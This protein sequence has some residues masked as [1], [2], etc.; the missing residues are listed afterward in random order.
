MEDILEGS[1]EEYVVNNPNNIVVS[2]IYNDNPAIVVVDLIN[3]DS[4]VQNNEREISFVLDLC[5]KHKIKKEIR[6]VYFLNNK[7]DISKV[8]SDIREKDPEVILS[9][10]STSLRKVF[11][12]KELYTNKI[13]ESELLRQIPIIPTYGPYKVFINPKSSNVE[14]LNKGFEMA[15]NTLVQT[16]VHT[17]NLLNNDK[18]IIEVREKLEKIMKQIGVLSKFIHSL[19]INDP[20]YDITVNKIEQLEKEKEDN[21]NI[22]RLLLRSKRMNTS[23]LMELFSGDRK[24]YASSEIILNYEQ[25]KKFCSENIDNQTEI[26]YDVETNALPVMDVNHEIV[27]FSLASEAS[28]G[29]YVPFKALDFKMNEEDKNKIIEDL[30]KTLLEKEIWVYNC[31]H[32]IPVV[33]NNYGIFL[34]DIKDLYVIIKLLNC[35]KPWESGSRTL[36]HQVS[37][38]LFKEDW[39]ED[40]NTYFTLFRQLN[41][42]EI[43]IEMK[44]LLSKYYELTEVEPTLEK[45]IERYEDLKSIL[46]STKVISY[47]NVPYKLIGRYG[48]LDSS[49]LFMLRDRYYEEITE[50]NDLLGIDLMKGFDLWQKIH[51]AHIMMEMNGLYLNDKKVQKLDNW[52][53]EQSKELM[54]QIVTSPLTRSWIK[55]NYWYE[56]SRN[57]LMMDYID[58]I[59]DRDTMAKVVQGRNGI[60]KDHIK[61]YKITPLF[62]H[63]IRKINDLINDFNAILDTGRDFQDEQTFD[64]LL[65]S[66]EDKDLRNEYRELFVVMNEISRSKPFV[67][68]KIEYSKGEFIVKLNWQNLLVIYRL[69]NFYKSNKNLFDE[70]FDTWLNEQIENSNTFDD[71]KN[72]FNVNSTVKVF[73]DYVS[74]ILLSRSIKI[75]HTYY[76][77]YEFIESASFEDDLEALKPK[78]PR[79]GQV[80]YDFM[81]DYLDFM[82]NTK[83]EE[84]FSPKRLEI[85]TDLF[86]K[87]VDIKFLNDLKYKRKLKACFDWWYDPVDTSRISNYYKLSTL[88]SGMIEHLTQ[89]YMMLNCNIDDRTTWTDEF[90]FMFNYKFIKKLIKAKST[91][92]D[93]STGR[94]NAYYID[95][96]YYLKETFPKRLSTY[97]PGNTINSVYDQDKAIEFELEDG[98]KIA[99]GLNDKVELQDGTIKLAKDITVEDDIIVPEHISMHFDNEDIDDEEEE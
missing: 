15:F 78:N 34:K 29:C 28:T 68:I 8:I 75:A 93:G 14:T 33:Y 65:G 40:L 47:E 31:Q 81:I 97:E 24:I 30:K 60:T 91:Y 25:Y 23:Q 48:S 94:G 2:G 46:S 36:K 76:K 41:K 21:S 56:F 53:D 37:T 4:S 77:I 64:Q 70:K 71:Y 63:I 12:T 72:L 62:I 79:Y 20:N 39:S 42:P 74:N 52:V 5:D 38:K 43:Q 11:K 61:F 26:G 86:N 55:G 27:G 83:D 80:H 58:D 57:V 6:R 32:E 95:K 10:G 85:F 82:S 99:F 69:S 22:L 17:S 87:Y 50:K 51:I 3:N 59:I 54:K 44:N 66:I 18:D 9:L 35:G 13:I 49:S 92:I 7:S 19:N 1:F 67:P 45:V 98:N 90:N 88:D 84:V 89:L 16:R 96:T 73:R